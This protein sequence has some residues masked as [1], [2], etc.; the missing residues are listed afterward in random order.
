MEIEK[1]LE[2]SNRKLLVDPAD[3]CMCMGKGGFIGGGRRI[4]KSNGS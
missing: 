2:R 3:W 1:D 4:E